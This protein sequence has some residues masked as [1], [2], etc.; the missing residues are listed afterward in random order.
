MFF[1]FR[2]FKAQ[3]FV[4]KS[5][6]IK[7]ANQ[8]PSTGPKNSDNGTSSHSTRRR[9][10]KIISYGDLPISPPRPV[11]YFCTTGLTYEPLWT[12]WT[13]WLRLPG[14]PKDPT[15]VNITVVDYA[16]SL[17]DKI[18]EFEPNFETPEDEDGD[19]LVVCFQLT[20]NQ[21]TF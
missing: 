1:F 18:R 6:F 2:R 13:L 16:N 9:G 7:L 3:E 5:T 21:I 17:Y 20:A 12:L 10:V 19:I 14:T 15:C 4:V 11:N 8:N